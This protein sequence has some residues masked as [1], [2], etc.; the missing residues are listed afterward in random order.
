LTYGLSLY[1]VSRGPRAKAMV[2]LFKGGLITLAGLFV[3]G[4]V[5][6]AALCASCVAAR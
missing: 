4:Q 3:L 5:A 1:A 6:S 2:A